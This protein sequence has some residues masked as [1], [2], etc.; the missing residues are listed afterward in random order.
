M[1]TKADTTLHLSTQA[2]EFGVDASL[3]EEIEPCMLRPARRVVI[4]GSIYF[5]CFLLC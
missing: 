1:N 5:S 4:G 2:W 3:V